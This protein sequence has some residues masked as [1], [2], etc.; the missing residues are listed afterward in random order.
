[1]T[2]AVAWGSGFPIIS[3]MIFLFSQ[4]VAS[5]MNSEPFIDSSALRALYT[6]GFAAQPTVLDPPYARLFWRLN[7]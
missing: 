2:V 3:G 4:A 5:E 7:T 6:L 1:M